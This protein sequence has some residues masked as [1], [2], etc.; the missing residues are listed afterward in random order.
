[1]GVI[2]PI[3]REMSVKETQRIIDH[4]KA[5][6]AH[7]ETHPGAGDGGYIQEKAER[8]LNYAKGEWK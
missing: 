8:I 1:M 6:I 4:A 2:L 3:S 7:C 5:I